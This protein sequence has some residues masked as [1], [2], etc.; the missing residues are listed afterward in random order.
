MLH[1]GPLPFGRALVATDRLCIGVV[2]VSPEGGDLD[3]FVFA[4]T[5]K[6]HMHDAK[7]PSND[8][9]PSEQGLDLFGGGVGGHIKIFWAQTQQQITHGTA[10]DVGLVAAI[11]QGL[12]HLQGPIIDQ[13]RIDAMRT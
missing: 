12:H 7:T 1:A 11:L 5:A 4:P 9:G 10:H 6:D 3:D 13:G 8:E 2:Q